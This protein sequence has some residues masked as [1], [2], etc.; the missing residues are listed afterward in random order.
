MVSIAYQWKKK[1]E[2]KKLNQSISIHRLLT[3]D[4]Q[5]NLGEYCPTKLRGVLIV[6]DDVIADIE[7]NKK[8]RP[9]VTEQ[10]LD[11]ISQSYFKVPKTRRL[12]ATHYF[13]H[14][15]T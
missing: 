7:A 15:N 4:V 9:I 11:F 2:I 14:E 3:N 8:L 5:E 1:V 10:P 13:F 12:N 6:F